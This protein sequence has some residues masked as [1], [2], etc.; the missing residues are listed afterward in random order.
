MVLGG[1]SSYPNESDGFVQVRLS[2]S[3]VAFKEVQILSGQPLCVCSDCE[4]RE[5]APEGRDDE[6]ARRLWDASARLVR[7]GDISSVSQDQTESH[8]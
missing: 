3:G 4:E 7:L 2:A 1:T 8:R 5:A 6:A